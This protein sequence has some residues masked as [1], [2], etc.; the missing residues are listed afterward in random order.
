MS[1]YDE[2]AEFRQLWLSG[3]PNT[4]IARRLGITVSQVQTLRR[5]LGLPRKPNQG[6][7][8]KRFLRGR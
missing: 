1:E 4:T 7:T 6:V 5:R 8:A 3:L 2:A